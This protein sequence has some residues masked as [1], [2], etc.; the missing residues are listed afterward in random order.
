MW[1]IGFLELCLWSVAE[2]ERTSVCDRGFACGIH[3][4]IATQPSVQA[5]A[6]TA[7]AADGGAACREQLG[8]EF[9]PRS[10]VE[11]VWVCCVFCVR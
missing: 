1:V 4:S 10:S 8:H 2:D 9:L 3:S 6:G 7:G 11:G 5:A